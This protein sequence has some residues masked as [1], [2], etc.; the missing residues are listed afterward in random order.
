MLP[1]LPRCFAQLNVR[2]A[3]TLASRILLN[4]ADLNVPCVRGGGRWVDVARA[5]RG[6][7][8]LDLG[9]LAVRFPVADAEQAAQQV[10]ARG[11]PLARPPARFP[12]AP[13][14]PVEA[15][16][17]KTPDGAL[18]EFYA[19]SGEAGTAAAGVPRAPGSPLAS[20]FSNDP[21]RAP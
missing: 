13:Y 3:A 5:G 20:G 12:L 11:W 1:Q 8:R 18:I 17:L 9:I 16:Q 10:T 2:V 19:A 6:R 21:G 7:V 14:G 4:L 15:F